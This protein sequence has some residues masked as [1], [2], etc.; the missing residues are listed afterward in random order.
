MQGLEAQ[1]SLLQEMERNLCLCKS[2]FSPAFSSEN[3]NTVI[4][5]IYSSWPE[6]ASLPSSFCVF[7]FFLRSP[8]RP[9]YHLEMRMLKGLFCH[10][11]V[12]VRGFAE[13]EVVFQGIRLF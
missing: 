5:S 6:A 3:D 11:V 12:Y 8:P 4:F 7:F 1:R 9:A 13:M 2:T 10:R